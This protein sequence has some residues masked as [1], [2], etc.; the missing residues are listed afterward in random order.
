MDRLTGKVAII[1]G[2]ATG[3]GQACGELFAREGAA[4]A[5]TDTNTT[6][7]NEVRLAIE[8]A[9]AR[10]IFLQHD[11]GRED[12]WQRVVAETVRAFG[13]LDIVVNNAGLGITGD[14]EHATLDEWHRLM[15][16]NLDGV[17]LG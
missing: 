15:R 6:G 7:G 13:K 8:R 4:V 1:T 3:I 11:V 2:G 10:A 5:L 16:V 17:F 9:G 14:V 12:D